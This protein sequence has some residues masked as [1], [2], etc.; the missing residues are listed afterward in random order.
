MRSRARPALALILGVSLLGGCEDAG[1]PPT[2]EA[3]CRASRPCRRNGVCAWDRR[4]KKCVV[5]SASDCAQA[6]ICNKDNKCTKVG[7]TCGAAE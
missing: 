7:D 1:P 5:G 6:E 4:T 2:N 3:E